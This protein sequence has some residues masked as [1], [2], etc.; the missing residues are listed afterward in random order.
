M[1][2]AD[3]NGDGRAEV[4]VTPDQGG[5]PVV[6]IFDGAGLTAGKNEAAQLARFFGIEDANFR[7][8]ARPAVGDVNG[9]GKPDLLVAA[10]FG[11]GPRLAVFNGTS[12]LAPVSGSQLPPK[13]V[14]DF[15]V[16][17]PTLRNGVFVTAGDLTGDG[18]AEVIVGGGP[19]GGPRVFALDGKA[20]VAG[21]QTPVANFFAGDSTSRGGV[22][23]G[24]AAGRLGPAATR[25]RQRGRR[26]GDGAGVQADDRPR[27]RGG[28]PDPN[29]VRRG[30][31]RR[32]RVRRLSGSPRPRQQG[33][34]PAAARRPPPASR[35]GA[36]APV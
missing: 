31:A 10:G 3:L 2:A 32:W 20:L 5:G 18:A 12:V 7:G 19:G 22:R 30:N 13:L 16:F 33:L 28:R 26:S 4:V 35:A 25:H 24:G 15:F 6:V 34:R 21:T 29:P 14:P 36:T 8:G 1:A 27:R 11:G 17:E 9:D 23:V